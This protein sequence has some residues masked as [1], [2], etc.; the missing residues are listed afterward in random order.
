MMAKGVEELHGA[1]AAVF[2]RAVTVN[3]RLTKL[4]HNAIETFLLVNAINASEY[5]AEKG[6]SPDPN[7]PGYIRREIDAHQV[8]VPYY[9]ASVLP[10]EDDLLEALLVADAMR[11]DPKGS[12]C[13]SGSMNY[14]GV[15]SEV[16]DLDLCE[17][18]QSNADQLSGHMLAKTDRE[19]P[20]VVRIKVGSAYFTYPW[21]NC[22]SDLDRLLK[23][24]TIR[25]KPARQAMLFAL[26]AS[27]RFGGLPVT[28]KVLPIDPHRPN[29]GGSGF[30]DSGIS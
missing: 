14:C 18:Y 4:E 29:C 10:V 11:L 2:W 9:L 27:A 5:Y 21:S 25:H 28:N 12:V 1:D 3:R 19:L 6:Y 24:G 20:T 22:T 17:Y 23:G 7:H 16:G 26:H 15:L 8:Y 13:L 30:L